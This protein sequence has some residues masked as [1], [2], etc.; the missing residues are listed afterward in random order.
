M[1]GPK[2]KFLVKNLVRQRC[3]EGFNSSVKGLNE[4]TFQKTAFSIFIAVR[5]S[6]GFTTSTVVFTSAVSLSLMDNNK[7][8]I[9]QGHT[10]TPRNKNVYYFTT[11]KVGNTSYEK[12]YESFKLL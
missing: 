5:N 8:I 10:Q 4:D 2:V 12:L 7:F 6:Y 1:N 3:A 9:L 11:L